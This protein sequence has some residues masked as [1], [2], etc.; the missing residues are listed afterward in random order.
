MNAF[1]DYY[2]LVGPGV[3][4]YL[5]CL[6]GNKKIAEKLLE[7]TFL[8]ARQLMMYLKKAPHLTIWTFSQAGKRYELYSQNPKD[9][10]PD[11]D[12]DAAKPQP[13]PSKKDRERSK[14]KG[15]KNAKPKEPEPE[16]VPQPLEGVDEEW[17]QLRESVM[18]LEDPVLRQVMALILFGGQS[19]REVS[20]I[21]GKTETWAKMSYYR[22][23]MRMLGGIDS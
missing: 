19:V 11:P 18:R 21:M 15:K 7:E 23:K 13:P 8:V 22:G 4:E 20:L 14:I 1:I 5:L 12:L 17:I 9:P 16:A 2:R 3:Y 6:T 10:D